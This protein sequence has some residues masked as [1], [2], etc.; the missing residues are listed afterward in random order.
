MKK[1]KIKN[2]CK[3]L[4][5]LSIYSLMISCGGPI[6]QRVAVEPEGDA[7]D[8]K[9]ARGYDPLEMSVDKKI[10]PK[11]H[12]RLGNIIGQIVDVDSSYVA[13]D[14]IYSKIDNLPIEADYLNSQAFRIQLFSSKVY[15]E[16]KKFLKVAEEIFD[17]P[18][19]MDY[20]VPYFKIRVGDF[21]NRDK[22]EEYQMR[23]KSSGY[24]NAWV[25]AVNINVKEAA[26]LYDEFILPEIIDSIF[27]YEQLLNN[28]AKDSID[29]N[30]SQE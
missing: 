30:D 22:A 19:Y 6:S 15:G 4:L 24:L 25:V 28:E 29:E 5:I 14:S 1:R 10:I 21:P 13:G 17:R 2:I 9:N 11:D 27:Y 3:I 8:A 20:E 12:P 18:I 26:P 7:S 23:C 16:A